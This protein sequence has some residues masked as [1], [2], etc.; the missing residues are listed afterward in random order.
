MPTYDILK[1]QGND[2]A[3][4]RNEH[5]FNCDKITTHINGK[6]TECIKHNEN[7]EQERWNNLSIEDKV[8]ELKQRL[9]HMEQL[10]NATF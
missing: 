8:N 10:K 5:C 4:I 6:C 9:D 3:F 1:H 7:K 2:M